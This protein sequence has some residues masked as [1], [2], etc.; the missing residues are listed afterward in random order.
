M[1]LHVICNSN[2]TIEDKEVSSN[3]NGAGY[4]QEIFYSRL[5]TRILS[6]LKKLT[7]N[8]K[9]I[10]V[11]VQVYGAVDARIHHIATMMDSGTR[12]FYIYTTRS[13]RPR[14]VFDIDD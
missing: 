14:D 11:R 12:C 6:V 5:Y 4:N 1:L 3:D 13:V 2:E 8:F 7:C 9:S 10:A